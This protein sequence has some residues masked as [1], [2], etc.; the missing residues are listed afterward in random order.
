MFLKG[1]KNI[2]VSRGKRLNSYAKTAVW[3]G[4]L[5]IIALVADLLAT[6]IYGSILGA[7]DYLN[8]I[9]V[10]ESRVTVGLMFEFIAAIAIILIPVALFPV[11]R[12]FNERSAI[13]YVVFRLFEGILLVFIIVST[14]SLIN[15]SQ[16]YVASGFSEAAYFQVQ[17]N[18]IQVWSD[19]A[20]LFYIAVFTLGALFFYYVLF[21]SRLLPRF[22][23]IW[24]LAAAALL[25][26]GT[27]FS[28]FD[29]VEAS[30]I[31]VMFGAPVALNEITLSI[32]LIAKKFNESVIPY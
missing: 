11:L 27:L 19:W 6:G 13:A 16:D 28:M 23:A 9:A 10:N 21:T 25:L 29:L 2:V 17:G 24:G 1:Y 18:S 3:A 15:L 20:T 7:E 26:S 32:W 8:Q 5:F 4:V 30:T 22:I 12:Q 14:F 31:M